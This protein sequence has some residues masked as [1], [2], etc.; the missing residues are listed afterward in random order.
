MAYL[1]R[2]DM[3]EE[4]IDLIPQPLR[5]WANLTKDVVFTG[6]QYTLVSMILNSFGVQLDPGLPL[7]PDLKKG[8]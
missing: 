5:E 2:A 3:R 8:F 6:A 7:D 4:P 1:R